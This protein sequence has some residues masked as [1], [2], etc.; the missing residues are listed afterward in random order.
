[1]KNEAERRCPARQRSKRIANALLNA[2]PAGGEVDNP[3]NSD[4]LVGSDRS[5]AAATT[6]AATDATSDTSTTSG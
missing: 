3:D 1:M 6:S 2:F 5:E 4:C